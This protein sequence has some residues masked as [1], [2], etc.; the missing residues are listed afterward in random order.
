MC[1]TSWACVCNGQLQPDVRCSAA[2]QLDALALRQPFLA[3]IAVPSF[4][5]AC[6]RQVERAVGIADVNS[7]DDNGEHE[8]A[9]APLSIFQMQLPVACLVLLGTLCSQSIGVLVR[10][11]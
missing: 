10:V 1:T 4:L 8:G 7:A 5:D 3:A 6:L 9:A 11:S 2:T